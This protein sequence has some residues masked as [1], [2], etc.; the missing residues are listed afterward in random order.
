MPKF[1]IHAYR[2]VRFDQEYT[3]EANCVAEATAKVQ[4]GEVEPTDEWE[5]D[6]FTSHVNIRSAQEIR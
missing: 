5:N 2:T 6:G 4:T 3:V 1:K